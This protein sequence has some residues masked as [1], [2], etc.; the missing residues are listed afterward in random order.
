MGIEI[1]I[2]DDYGIRTP[3]IDPDTTSSCGEEV[4]E[5]IGI[6]TVEFV[7]ALLAIG[8]LRISILK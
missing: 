4:D 2:E 5:Y 7:H 8:L 6:R 1:W 3:E